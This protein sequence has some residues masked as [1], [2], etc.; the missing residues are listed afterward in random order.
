MTETSDQLS[1]IAGAGGN[2]ISA[3]GDKIGGIGQIYRDNDSGEPTWVTVKAGL[4]GST[5]SFV[6][7][8]GST[9]D[10]DNIVVAYDRSLVK[11]SPRVAADGAITPQ[12]ESQL[13]AYYNLPGTAS[14]LPV[15]AADQAL[16][17]GRTGGRGDG[18]MTR[19]EEQL[20]VGVQ[21][22]VKERV[23]VRKYIVTEEVTQTV[24]VRREELRIER[25]PISEGTGVDASTGQGAEEETLE[26]VLYAER[27]VLHKEIVPVERVRV[28]KEVVT[29][30]VTIA[31]DLRKERIDTEFEDNAAPGR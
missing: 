25:E 4:F 9:F 10:G 11:D 31:E 1:R 12:E 15:P 19:S 28:T 5:E 2:V 3:T 13:A 7:L 21:R 16:A 14:D 20:R 27:P 8:Q 23:R 6:P 30:Q 24:V 17:T 29:E 18:A 26:V 22:R